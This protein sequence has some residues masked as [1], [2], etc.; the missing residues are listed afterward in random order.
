MEPVAPEPVPDVA[1]A[2]RRLAVEAWL[3]GCA[4]TDESFARH[5]LYTWT[6]PDQIE[7]LREPDA[8]LLSRERSEAGELS[9]FDQAIADDDHPIARRLRRRG[10]RARRFAWVTPWATRMGW[11][12]GDYGDRLIEVTLRAEAWTARFDPSATPRWRVV[13]AEGEPVS[14]ADVRRAPG[15]VAAVYHVGD[16]PRAFREVVLVNEAQIERWAY[17]TEDLRRGAARDAAQLRALAA[18][19]RGEAPSPPSDLDEWLRAGWAI[20]ADDT[21]LERYRGCL[22]LGSEAYAPTAAHLDAIAAA[23]ALPGDEPIT[24]TVRVRRRRPRPP[25]SQPAHTW[26]DPTMGCPP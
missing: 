6:R 21:L 22:A 7:A 24:R 3:A 18:I 5:K 13:D 8:A 20:P 14:E 12:G 23:L 4:V 26:C 15:R 2:R 1:S 9:L 10:N 11:E 25:P 16:G 17:A 19:W